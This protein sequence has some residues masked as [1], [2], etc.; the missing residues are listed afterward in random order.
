MKILLEINEQDETDAIKALKEISFSNS[1]EIVENSID[2][3]IKH[4]HKASNESFNKLWRGK[5]NDHW[6]DFL[7]TPNDTQI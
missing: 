5:H 7:S 3:E 1:I 6:D 2:L 4:I